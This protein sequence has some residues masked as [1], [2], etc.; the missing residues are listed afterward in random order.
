MDQQ[1]IT[2][3]ATYDLKRPLLRWVSKSILIVNSKLFAN[4]IA[5]A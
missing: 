2:D 3:G 4:F 1:H 5:K